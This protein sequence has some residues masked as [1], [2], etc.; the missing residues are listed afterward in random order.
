MNL[1]R[2]DREAASASPAAGRTD[3]VGAS[4]EH[5][6]LLPVIMCGGA[7]SRLWPVSREAHPK[8]FIRLSDGE[9]LL[10]KA[11]LRAAALDGVDEILTVTNRELFFKSEDE[12][13]E[14]NQRQLAMSFI[15]E[16]FGRNTAPAVAAAALHVASAHGEQTVMLVLAADHVI[17]QFDAFADAVRRAQALALQGKI[18]TFGVHPDA[19]ETAYGYIE[20]NGESV[21]R[22]V[23][24]PKVDD[25][26]AYLESG[27]FLWNSGMFCFTAGTMLKEM[28]QH[29][30]DVLEQVRASLEQSPSSASPHGVQIR[31]DPDSF[32]AVP[33]ISVDY[34]VMEKCRHAAVVPC[35]IGWSDVGSWA[36]LSELSEADERGNRIEGEALLVDVD[37]T[38][39]HSDSRL[40]GAVGVRNLLVIDTPDALLVADRDR[41]QDVKHVYAELKA[42]GHEAYK[43]HRTVHR[44]WGTYTVLEEGPRFKI[45]R[46]V[47]KPGAS[48]SL[49][50]HHHRSEHWV[51]VSGMAKVVNGDREFLVAIDESTYIPAGHKH[52]L[53]NPGI[54]DLVMIEV[55]SGEYLGEDDI[56]RFEDNYGRT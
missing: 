27:R 45:K 40:I 36:S 13:R 16:P 3:D 23:E 5:V 32:G 24:K 10:Q 6:R 35:D 20:T 49:Q 26:R 7:G 2:H 28:A 22:F 11:F 56:V 43:V 19:P 14:V 52:R 41:A 39:V 17:T 30:P 25:A 50:M 55:Q 9:S 34:A 21:V 42:R 46:I 8:P 31:L 18:V 47:V 51:V 38:F 33:D 12:F 1:E 15:L 53:E 4:E 29:C 54:V 37:N 48:L 44:P